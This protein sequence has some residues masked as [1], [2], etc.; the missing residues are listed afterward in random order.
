M[1]NK[2]TV[3]IKIKRTWLHRLA[4]WSIPLVRHVPIVN[5]IVLRFMKWV[6][7]RGLFIKV[8]NKPW[9]RLKR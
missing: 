3:P 9:E 6:L 5:R 8:G 4:V 7:F 1:P 2:L